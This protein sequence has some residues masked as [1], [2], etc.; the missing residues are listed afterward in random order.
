MQSDPIY[1][2]RKNAFLLSADRSRLDLAVIHSFLAQSYWARGIP[3]EIVAR[4]VAN[5]LCFGLY[6][7]EKQIGFARVISD[8]ATYAYIG[9]LFILEPYR[10][11]GL[12]KWMMECITQHPQL[13]G[14]R[15]WTLLTSDAHALY[16]QFGFTPLHSPERYMELHDPNIY[17][18]GTGGKTKAKMR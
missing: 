14:L 6:S 18:Q 15:R 11:R 1:E 17:A 13:Q 7:A 10:G 2:Y 5:S 12:A 4:S 8:F 9:D 3:R 16:A